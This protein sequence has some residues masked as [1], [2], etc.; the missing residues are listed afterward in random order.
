MISYNE[1][2]ELLRKEK[3][4]ET[5]QV[6]PKNF[7]DDFK[8]YVLEMKREDSGDGGLFSESL[9]KSKKQFE[10]ALS[11]FRELVLRRKRKILNLVFVATETGIMK[12][13]Y[14]NMLDFERTVF[15]KMVNA[16][17]QGDKDLNDLLSGKDE[18]KSKH[19][20]IVFSDDAEEFVDFKGNSVG[21]FK[22]GAYAN[23]DE[24]VAEIL[25]SGGKAKYVDED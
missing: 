5:L 18:V 20:L 15:D 23:L 19:K 14:E 1:L 13:D 16:F 11:I 2:Y 8:Q 12:R 6:L 10:N 4:S 22:L 25:V 21:P 9:A 7:L 24:E 17:E 3:Y